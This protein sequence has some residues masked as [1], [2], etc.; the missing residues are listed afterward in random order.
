MEFEG[1]KRRWFLGKLATLPLAFIDMAV[2]PNKIPPFSEFRESVKDGTDRLSGLWVE[3][4]LASPITQP[5][6]N[7]DGYISS[8]SNT[9][10]QFM[11]PEARTGTN[12]LLA[13]NYLAGG[14]FSKLSYGDR[15]LLVN[16][17]SKVKIFEVSGLLKF[18][19]LTQKSPTSEFVN[20]AS[21]ERHTAREVFET[22]YDQNPS[23]LVLQTCIAKN[24]DLNWGRLFVIS[25]QVD[26]NLKLPSIKQPS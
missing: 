18:Q 8:D 25:K 14:T 6:K 23:T 13:H 5:L 20:L 1:R 22:V 24:G 3:G 16:G 4:L 9:L 10:T 11:L 12:A 19:A 26:N 21:D 15:L 17:T 2:N 7:F